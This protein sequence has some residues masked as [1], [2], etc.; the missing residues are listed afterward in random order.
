METEKGQVA[1]ALYPPLLPGIWQFLYIM[2]AFSLFKNLPGK[3]PALTYNS[4]RPAL[5]FLLQKLAFCMIWVFS[6]GPEAGPDT[7]GIVS[8]HVIT[9]S[10]TNDDAGL[11][12]RH[13][14]RL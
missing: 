1:L 6:Q 2:L 12:T 10:H 7:L 9:D 8:Q 13:S 11:G 4:H 5:L 14:C 3:D